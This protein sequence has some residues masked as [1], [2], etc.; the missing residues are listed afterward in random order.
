M[1]H[2]LHD[3]LIRILTTDGNPVRVG[4]FAAE[5]LI[6]TRAHVIAQANGSDDSAHFDLPLLASGASFSRRVLF[7]QTNC[8]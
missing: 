8:P 3:S 1:S 7:L 5:N 6:L 4:F 2:Q